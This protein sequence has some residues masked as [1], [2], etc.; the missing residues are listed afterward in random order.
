MGCAFQGAPAHAAQGKRTLMPHRAF[1]CNI[2]AAWAVDREFVYIVGPAWAPFD[3]LDHLW[4]PIGTLLGRLWFL[5]FS[6]GAFGIPL[7]SR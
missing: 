2:T 1:H 3:R 6:L 5:C 7:D 4:D